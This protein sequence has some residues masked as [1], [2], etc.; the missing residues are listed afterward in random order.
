[1]MQLQ[2]DMPATAKPHAVMVD[3]RVAMERTRLINQVGV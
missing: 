1:M 3:E 2:T